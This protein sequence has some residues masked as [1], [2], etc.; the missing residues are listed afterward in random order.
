MAF[1]PVV[2]HCRLVF[3]TPL[4]MLS[5]KHSRFPVL[6]CKTNSLI[7]YPSIIEGIPPSKMSSCHQ[8][9]TRLKQ[10]QQQQQQNMFSSKPFRPGLFGI[11]F[12]Y[13]YTGIN[14]A[15]LKINSLTLNDQNFSCLSSFLSV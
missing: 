9:Y 7:A 4:L 13:N 11:L 6:V 2:A 8:Q 12:C 10:Q 15:S 1:L 14:E 5:T 3:P